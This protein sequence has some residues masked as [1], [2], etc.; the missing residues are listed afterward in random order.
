[1]SRRASRAPR[2]LLRGPRSLA[3]VAP[4]GHGVHVGRRDADPLQPRHGLFG[5]VR[6]PPRADLRSALVSGRDLF[7]ARQGTSR[8]G[9]AVR[10]IRRREE[11]GAGKGRAAAA[12]ALPHA[13]QPRPPRVLPLDERHA[14]GGAEHGFR[15][16]GRA[17]RR[18]RRGGTFF[19]VH[20]RRL[21]DVRW[22]HDDAAAAAEAAP[23]DFAALPKAHGHL[24]P[25]SVHRTSREH[26][27]PR[28]GRG[29]S[30]VSRR[31]ADVR[32]SRPRLGR[33]EPH[34][35]RRRRPASQGSHRQEDQGRGAE[36][37]LVCVLGLVR[38]SVV[39]RSVR[40]LRLGRADGALARVQDDDQR[41]AP[42]GL[43]RRRHDRA[44]PPRPDAAPSSRAPVRRQSC[45]AGGLQRT[46]A[47]GAGRRLRPRPP[48]PAVRQ[49]RRQE[50]A[51][52]VGR[53]VLQ[54]PKVLP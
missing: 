22:F 33:L 24:Q 30:A 46:S 52:Q 14:A 44:A 23:D 11:L 10:T 19:C 53:P 21:L 49:G 12:D 41:R 37:V 5:A 38:V 17:E 13:R 2:P 36:S 1:M 34:S 50:V 7:V 32:G 6:V 42:R 3:D 26:A 35:G 16:C 43:G 18:R 48:R 4:A 9:R 39:A 47:R 25:P 27:R 31:L 15:R 45:C 51:R 29:E 8:S 54:L 20:V 28:P 40:L